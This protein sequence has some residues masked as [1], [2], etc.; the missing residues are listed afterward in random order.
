[1][2]YILINKYGFDSFNE[3]IIARGLRSLSA[4][5]ANK[6]DM[7]LIDSGMVNNT[8]YSIAKVAYVVKKIQKGYLY[9]YSLL[10][11]FGLLS[12]ILLLVYY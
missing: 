3:N 8:G 10:M 6:C 11:I 5:L 9:N 7:G 12:L 4:I 2:N 1:L